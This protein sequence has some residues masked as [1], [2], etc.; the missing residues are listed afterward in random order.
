MRCDEFLER[1]DEAQDERRSW[2]DDRALAE[3]ADRCQRC[4]ALAANYELIAV[5]AARSRPI[6]PDDLR[7]RVMAGLAGEVVALDRREWWTR[8]AWHIAGMALAAAALL[9]VTISLRGPIADRRAAPGAPR[10][11]V[12]STQPR[13][14]EPT[15]APKGARPEINDTVR[16]GGLASQASRSYLN[17]ARQTNRGL[18]AA[19]AALP[20][21]GASQDDETSAVESEKAWVDE[22]ASGLEPMTTSAGGAI[23][24]LFR[25]FDVRLEEEAPREASS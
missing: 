5:C 17:L 21:F 6:P 10:L 3:H 9:A 22:V 19:L 11:A 20:R 13:P 15:V 1:L 24:S 2:S 25:A 23:Q 8:G 12:E 16:S 4:R 14:K 18:S 7:D